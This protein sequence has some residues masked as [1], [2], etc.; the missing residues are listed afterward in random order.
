MKQKDKTFSFS[1]EDFAHAAALPAAL[2]P[3][4]D[5]CKREMPWRGAADAYAVWVSEIML[6]QT[7]VEA[8]RGYFVRFMEALPTPQALAQ[9]PEERLMKLWQGLGYYNRARNMQRAAR[10]VVEQHGGKLP[11]SY[12]ALAALPGIGDYTAGAVASIAYGLPVPCVDGNVLRVLSRILANGED[13][14]RPPVKAAYRALAQAMI[15]EGRAGD[16]NQSLMELGATVCLP[17]GAP[18]CESCPAAP[19][20]RA[21]LAGTQTDYPVKPPKAARRV[22]QRTVLLAVHAGRVLLCQRPQRGLLAGLWEYPAAPGWLSPEE[23]TAF[24]ARFG[25]PA[26]APVPLGGAKHIFTH[27][28]WHMR[29]YAVP[30]LNAQEGVWATPD[31]LAASYALPS[32]LRAYTAQVREVCRL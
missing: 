18:L 13:V 7:R 12:E 31:E 28:E 17:N 14:S 24:A 32:A 20:C 3:W 4:Y 5:R 21:R 9:C 29:G 1:A 2:L 26:A 10:M 27:L 8:V 19:L 6:Q 16:F 23:T 30:L 25:T 11:Q 22:E 15:P